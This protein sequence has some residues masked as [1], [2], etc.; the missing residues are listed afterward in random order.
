MTS[1]PPSVPR[2]R[3][4][5]N[6]SNI[7]WLGQLAC[8]RRLLTYIRDAWSVVEPATAFLN[9]WHLDLIAEYLEAVTA[10]QIKRLLIN[11]PPR[12]GKSRLV[13]IFWPT[14]CWTRRAEDKL[15]PDDILSGASSHWIFASFA[16]E[17]VSD[18]SVQRRMIMG[19]PWYQARWGDRV[20]FSKDQNRKTNYQNLKRGAM[21]STSISGA[22]GLG[23][24]GNGIVIDDPHNTKEAESDVQ[25]KAGIETFR[26]TL[27][28]RHDDKMRGVIVIIMQR[29]N[30]LDLSGYLLELG[31]FEHL[32]IQGEY[33]E[34]KTYVFPRSKDVLER[35]ETH[36]ERRRTAKPDAAEKIPDGGLLWPAREGPKEIAE[37]KLNLGSMGFAA[38][39]QGRPAPKGGALFKHVWWRYWRTL[40]VLNRII[41]VLD[42]AYEE[43][44]DHSFSNCDVW[45][46]A[47]I[48][49][50]LV[51][52]WH[53]R[54]EF[55]ELKRATIWMA[56]KWNPE[57]ILIEARAS[58]RSLIQELR[59]P[60]PVGSNEPALHA[61]IP[62]SPIDPEVDK[63]TRAVAI[64]PIPEAGLVWLPDK[65]MPASSRAPEGYGWV[66]GYEQ[67]LE[68]FPAG[69]LNDRVDTF[70]HAITN[71]RRMRMR[72]EIGYHRLLLSTV[73]SKPR[74]L[75]PS[76]ILP[77]T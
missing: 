52:N 28:T 38:Q 63:Y 10:G 74:S 77:P 9:N 54:V 21:F 16:D 2:R 13:S 71:L 62:I 35:H 34:P 31:G 76:H 25:R 46:L 37:R 72:S 73:T 41:M 32:L 61:S 39:Y 26:N 47:D 11:V 75:R 40:P 43:G 64:T 70:V 22:A 42:T 48:G 23:K 19:S 66:D 49:F 8:E 3:V 59:R 12:Y 5:R 14:W 36:S 4:P 33:E 20:S 67:E 60:V 53:R 58:G 45:G 15:S 51:D 27:S 17:L 55:P 69:K 18:L 57:V 56:A 1:A 44:D 50:V 68:L 6:L 7:D 30:E 29:L 65:T 24:G